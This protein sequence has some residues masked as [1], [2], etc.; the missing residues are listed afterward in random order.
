MKANN[1]S[2]DLITSYS[3]FHSLVIPILALNQL[4]NA[5]W[6]AYTSSTVNRRMGPRNPMVF[7]HRHFGSLVIFFIGA[8]VSKQIRLPTRRE[9]PFIAITGVL[10]VWLRAAM[11]SKSR[12]STSPYYL[13]LWQPLLPVF[14]QA[15]TIVLRMEPLNYR[16]VIGMGL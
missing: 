16:K 13:S 10:G 14:V 4:A 1:L 3:T 8:L 6:G 11:V 7:I 2:R 15:A 5:G 12:G 9:I